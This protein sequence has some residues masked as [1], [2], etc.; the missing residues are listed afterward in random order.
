MVTLVTPN[1]TACLPTGPPAPLLTCFPLFPSCPTHAPHTLALAKVSWHK[2]THL[3]PCSST[4]T[5]AHVLNGMFATTLGKLKGTALA[6]GG[7]R[8]APLFIWTQAAG[9]VIS[10]SFEVGIYC[11]FKSVLQSCSLK[12]FPL[13]PGVTMGHICSCHSK[14]PFCPLGVDFPL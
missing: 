10:G 9:I 12:K 5:P 11:L 13:N 4:G 1:L 2:C 8:I 14:W 7:F 6:Q 3:E